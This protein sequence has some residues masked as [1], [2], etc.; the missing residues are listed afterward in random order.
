M[1]E[2]SQAE[3]GSIS[4]L[5]TKECTKITFKISPKEFCKHCVILYTMCFQ[6]R[7]CREQ[8]VFHIY[9]HIHVQ[10]QMPTFPSSL[11]VSE[12]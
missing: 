10:D 1:A 6:H 3:S 2:D 5:S 12:M 9:Q 7:K 8:L 11:L 4:N